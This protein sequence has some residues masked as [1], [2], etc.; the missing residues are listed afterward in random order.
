MKLA[1]FPWEE[2]AALALLT[3]VVLEEEFGYE[4]EVEEARPG[5][6]LEAV[7]AGE[8]DALQGIWR[9]AQ[10]DLLA[11]HEGELDML[12]Q[13]LL[14]TTR[15][16]LAAP[17]YMNVRELG[18]LSGAGT[19]A[20]FLEEGASGVG[21]V[22]GEV[23]ER[24][25]L[26]PSAYAE[27]GTMLEEA[28]RLYEAG[29]PFVVLAY[30]PHRMNLRFDLDYLEGGRLLE[31][32]NRPSTLHSAARSGLEGEDSLAHAF[33]SEMKLTVPQVESLEL[34]AHEA[35]D[36]SDGVRDWA[37]S[38]GHVTGVWVRAAADRGS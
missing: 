37:A 10:N 14:G 18:E 19:K 5:E 2:S 9:P 21:T 33:L 4:V 13:S 34:A 26:E 12:G 7:S 29:E 38:H 11:R 23:F 25:D 8:A 1:H 32:V 28:E 36:P 20:L 27:A 31:E 17:S 16:S 15:S 35:E 30:S 22:P 24:H 6:A 3:E